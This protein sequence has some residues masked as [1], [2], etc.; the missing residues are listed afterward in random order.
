MICGLAEADSNCFSHAL[1]A[2]SRTCSNSFRAHL[3]NV[4]ILSKPFNGL[5]REFLLPLGGG[6]K[7]RDDNVAQVYA[8]QVSTLVNDSSVDSNVQL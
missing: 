6:E 1:E 5:K 3:N 7:A 8:V 4:C 2:N